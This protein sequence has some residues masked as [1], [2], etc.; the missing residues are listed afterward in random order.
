[1]YLKFLKI[2]IISHTRQQKKKINTHSYEYFKYIFFNFPKKHKK[3]FYVVNDENDILTISI[4]GF[5]KKNVIYCV[6]FKSKRIRFFSKLLLP[7]L[8]L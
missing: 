1:M 6:I 5:Y 8:N 4:F 3:I 7:C 2:F